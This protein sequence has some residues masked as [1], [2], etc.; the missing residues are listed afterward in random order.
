VLKN[1]KMAYPEDKK[2]MKVFYKVSSLSKKKVCGQRKNVVEINS[3]VNGRLII[4]TIKG[5]H[6]VHSFV[7]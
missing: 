7:L 1:L 5:T 3:F 4:S 2:R 6:S